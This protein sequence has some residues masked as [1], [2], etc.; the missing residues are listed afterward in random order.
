MKEN[1]INSF[2]VIFVY[3]LSIVGWLLKEIGVITFNPLYLQIIWGLLFV[4]LVAILLLSLKDK[5]DS[6]SGDVIKA[7]FKNLFMAGVV[8]LTFALYYF[9]QSIKAIF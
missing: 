9:V 7:S 2:F 5:V 6:I 3:I 8:G 4:D 1:K